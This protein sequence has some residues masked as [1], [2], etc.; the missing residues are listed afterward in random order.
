VC[1]WCLECADPNQIL[2]GE[3]QLTGNRVNDSVTYSCNVGYSLVGPSTAR[4]HFTSRWIFSDNTTGTT[5]DGDEDE[6]RKPPS[7]SSA[8]IYIYIYIYIERERERDLYLMIGQIDCIFTRQLNRSSDLS[9]CNSA[10]T[11]QVSYTVVFFKLEVYYLD[12]ANGSLWH[13]NNR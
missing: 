12:H 11:V 5:S 10:T 2:K 1:V 8:Y 3:Y 13:I 4:C 7:C 6:K 9:T